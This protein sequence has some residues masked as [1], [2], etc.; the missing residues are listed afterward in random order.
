M[1]FNYIRYDEC[2]SYNEV[3]LSPTENQSLM[4]RQIILCRHNACDLCF[5]R[6]AHNIY[7]RFRRQ[8][9]Q[10]SLTL[11]KQ[12]AKHLSPIITSNYTQDDQCSTSAAGEPQQVQIR[13]GYRIIDINVYVL[14]HSGITNANVPY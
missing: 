7:A 13:R 14:K 12:N 11:G 5:T 6:F 9:R 3:Y 8:R 10:R 4:I 1:R 2:C